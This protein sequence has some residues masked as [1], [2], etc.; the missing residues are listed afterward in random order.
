M[1]RS[2]VGINSQISNN[3]AQIMQKAQNYSRGFN[4]TLPSSVNFLKTGSYKMLN[5]L[6]VIK[7]FHF[8]V[9]ALAQE[10]NNSNFLLLYTL[11]CF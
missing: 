1:K 6:L 8:Y 2:A 4:S 10:G 5:V 7:L 3:M 11:R 9:I